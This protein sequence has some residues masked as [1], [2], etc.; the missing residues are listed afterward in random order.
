MKR[1]RRDAEY[2]LLYFEYEKAV[3]LLANL[4][5]QQVQIRAQIK[6]LDLKIDRAQISNLRG[7]LM[8]NRLGPWGLRSLNKKIRA[9]YTYA[10]QTNCYYYR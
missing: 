7:Q 8:R 10:C 2:D 9:Y 5:N 6:N 4:E 1:A 3:G